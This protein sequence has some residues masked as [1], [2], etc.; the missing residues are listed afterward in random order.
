M[1]SREPQQLS[2]GFFCKLY[3]ECKYAY[4]KAVDLPFADS[5]RA[6]VNFWRKNVHKY[7]LNAY[8]TKPVQEKCGKVN[9]LAQHDPKGLTG[10]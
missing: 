7:W 6:D 2:I 9:R 1:T 5:R 8:R 4:L 3:L 10:Q